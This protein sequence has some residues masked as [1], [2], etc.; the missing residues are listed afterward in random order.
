SKSPFE[1]KKYDDPQQM[2]R[3]H[4]PNVSRQLLGRH[5]NTVNNVAHFVSPKLSGRVSDYFFDRLNHFTIVLSSVD[6]VLEEVGVQ[7]LEELTQDTERSK[8]ISHAFGEQN[9]WIAAVQGAFSG[10]TGVIGTAI[11]I[12][13]SMVLALRTIYQVG[14]SYGF[15]LSKEEDQDIVQ[16]IFRQIDLSLIA[17]KQTLLMGLKAITSTLKSHDISQL[18]AMLG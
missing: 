17:E 9:K 7:D 11:D 4:L 13:A 2:L 1:S 6:R 3:E 10:A 5:F 8:R 12:P 15:D 18:Q 14:R 16:H